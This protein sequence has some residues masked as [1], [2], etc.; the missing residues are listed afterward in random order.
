MVPHPTP[1]SD[2]DSIFES[3]GP[4]MFV[5]SCLSNI[6]INKFV[7]EEKKS[8]GLRKHR[9]L[10]MGVQQLYKKSSRC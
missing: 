4:T 3:W 10:G 1:P 9:L 6:L 2:S 7:K 8:G 5:D